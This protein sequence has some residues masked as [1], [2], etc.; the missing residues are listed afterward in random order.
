M[1]HLSLRAEHHS[2]PRNNH[3][4]DVVTVLLLNLVESV[5]VPDLKR[6]NVPL[7]NVPILNPVPLK[8]ED[9]AVAVLHQE[10]AK[11]E[12]KAEAVAEA[13]AEAVNQKR[14]TGKRREAL[15]VANLHLKN[16]TNK[17]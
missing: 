11:L 3:T 15:D 12:E 14:A 2:N 9:P 5:A 4:A 7:K 8:K 17:Y 13:E 6:P 1:D 16:T 10:N